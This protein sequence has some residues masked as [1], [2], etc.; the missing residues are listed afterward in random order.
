MVPYRLIKESLLSNDSEHNIIGKVLGMADK[1]GV[2]SEDVKNFSIAALIM[3][4]REQ[5]NESEHGIL[6]RALD[7]ARQLG[8]DKK[9]LNS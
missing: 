4:L 1:Y 2:T 7:L 8:I 6:S 3:Q 9:P 5:A